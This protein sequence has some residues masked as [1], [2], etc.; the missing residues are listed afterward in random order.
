MESTLNPTRSTTFIID[1]RDRDRTLFPRPSHY[2][3]NL[4]SQAAIRPFIQQVEAVHDVVSMRLLVADV[5][6]VAYLVQ[7]TNNSIQAVITTGTT[8]SVIDATIPVGNYLGPDLAT[9]VQVAL[10]SG[11]SSSSFGANY[12]SLTDNINVTCD[13]PFALVFAA[14]GS[15]A[16]E[17]GYA[18]GTTYMSIPQGSGSNIVTP[19]FR[20]DSHLN[21][22]VILSILPASVNTSVNTC[23]D[24]SFAIITPQRSALSAAGEGLP[25]KIFNPP[26]ARFSHVTVD[27]KNHDGTPVDFQNHDHRLEI[28]LV[29]LRAAK[30]QKFDGLPTARY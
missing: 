18:T 14:L 10:Q 19:P 21:P 23:V 6:F 24:Q 8:A 28:L 13:H 5:P 1:S 7:A 2:E 15:V 27:F 20:R 16:L 26:I 17:L 22:A 9:A 30:Y 29:S 25:L 11:T 12:S 4:T 3:I